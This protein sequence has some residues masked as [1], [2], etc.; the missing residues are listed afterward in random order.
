MTTLWNTQNVLIS[1]PALCQA[2]Y[3]TSTWKRQGS[4]ERLPLASFFLELGELGH[5]YTSHRR[6]VHSEFPFTQDFKFFLRYWP[7]E[8]GEASSNP[9]PEFVNKILHPN[10]LKDFK[11]HLFTITVPFTCITNH[12][13]HNKKMIR[14]FFLMLCF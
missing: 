9:Q 2:S 1:L 5:A 8:R 6:A 14:A 11:Q 13:N 10:T 4:L 7:A 3:Y 12:I